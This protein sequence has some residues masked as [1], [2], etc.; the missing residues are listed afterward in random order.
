M[1]TVSYLRPVQVLAKNEALKRLLTDVHKQH[2]TDLKGAE[3]QV[4]RRVWEAEERTDCH[5]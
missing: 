2:V 4:D 5:A 1:I 3:E